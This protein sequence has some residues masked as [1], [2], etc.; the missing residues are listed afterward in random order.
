MPVRLPP[1]MRPSPLG[2]RLPVLVAVALSLPALVPV[3]RTAHA[4][5]VLPPLTVEPPKAKA[6][7]RTKAPAKAK[8]EPV[9]ASD[10]DATSVTKAPSGSLTVPT[11]KETEA[12]LAKVPG[13]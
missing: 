1:P 13:S 10:K 5:S 9:A 6:A 3:G 2:L 4:Q 11:A 7:P 12:E 8:A